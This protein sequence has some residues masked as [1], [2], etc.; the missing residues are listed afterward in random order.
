MI[1]PPPARRSDG[2]AA[3]L[4]RYIA[5]TFTSSARSHLSSA[6]VSTVPPTTIVPT[7]ALLNT[8]SSRP[9]APTA[10]ATTD[11]QSSGRARSAITGT[12]SAPVSRTAATVRSSSSPRVSARVSRAPARANK[13]AVARPI[14]V[15]AP[16]MIATL[17]SSPR[18]A[19][20][21]PTLCST[22]EPLGREVHHLTQRSE[23][24]PYHSLLHQL[25]ARERAEAAVDAG[26][27]ARAVADRGHRRGD[28]V[29]DHLRML[30][31]VRRRV[32]DAGQEQH[33]A[34]ERMLAERLQFVLMA[35][36]RERQ[37]ERADLGPV[38]DRQERLERHV[39]GVGAV[40]IAPAEVQ[41]HAV[42]GDRRDRLVGRVDVERDGC[43]KAVE[44]FVLEEARALHRQ[45]RAV[46]LEHEATR[47]DQLVLAAHL[48]GER[49][50]VALVR[51]VEGVEHDGGDDAG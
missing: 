7:P 3:R 18:P 42:S 12:A 47:H 40:V 6:I 41:A 9:A 14:P 26:E 21:V 29:G 34:R 16:V 45:I 20:P 49:S 28:A 35:R 1:E 25:R 43:E 15:A 10:A 24:R 4:T 13:R 38:D 32:D 31:D 27:H 36:A 17:P 22:P 8:T 23:F 2:S 44:G 51:S 50:D 48:T 19:A 30:D 5:R 11:A 39:V 46:E 37:R 33:V